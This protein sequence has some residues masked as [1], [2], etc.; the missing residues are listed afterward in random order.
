MAFHNVL[1]A[2]FFQVFLLVVPVISASVAICRTGWTVTADSYQTGNE[3]AKVL[4]GNATTF[5]HTKYSPTPVDTLPH[6]IVVDM[7]ATYNV[8]A[9]SIQPRPSGSANGRIGG[10]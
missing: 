9:V 4:D 5:W 2:R 6:W 10:H 8:G 7:K 1:V 3:P